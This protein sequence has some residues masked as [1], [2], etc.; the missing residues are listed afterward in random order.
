[1]TDRTTLLADLAPELTDCGEDTATKALASILNKDEACL[2]AL[3]DLLR[4]EGFD[5][6]AIKEV[7]T[8]VKKGR[9]R[10]D[11]TGY[12]GYERK[13]LLVEAKFWAELGQD[14]ASGY[15]DHLDEEGP[16]VLLF[17]VLES[18]R[19]A[20]WKEIK[21]QM[22]GAGK[23]LEHIEPFEGGWRTRIVGSDKRLMLV[24]WD[25]LLHR[26][27]KAVPDD[28]STAS[29]IQQLR[30]L[31]QWQDHRDFQP[32]QMEELNI[33]LPRMILSINWLIYFVI[34]HRYKE[35]KIKTKGRRA[36]PQPEGYGLYFS[37]KGIKGKSKF[38]IGVN[39]DLW[40]T[41]SKT[42]LWLSIR[43]TVRFDVEKLEGEFPQMRKDT[44][45]YDIPIYLKTGEEYQDV[46]DDVVSQ[47]GKIRD[48]VNP[49]VDPSTHPE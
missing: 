31:A 24:G 35:L 37:F 27:A 9:S 46:L 17:I 15:F 18:T 19:E 44:N 21:D 32:I 41:R 13:R 29:D 7:A 28:S 34:Y 33:S 11:M 45:W 5:L 14:Q 6:E 12:D 22:D 26:M 30:D 20:L 8:Q 48:V 39:F 36:A 40:A 4:D 10:P 43:K 42:P 38:F 23:K 49:S 3:N 1:M 16:G 25:F 47:I 2:R